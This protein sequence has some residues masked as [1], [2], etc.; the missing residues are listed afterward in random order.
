MFLSIA[1]SRVAPHWFPGVP[2]VDNTVVE[3]IRMLAVLADRESELLRC[4]INYDEP[5]C[6][7]HS[8]C[9]GAY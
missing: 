6:F 4:H 2:P 7:Y 5:Y 1:L 8:F 3:R 9:D